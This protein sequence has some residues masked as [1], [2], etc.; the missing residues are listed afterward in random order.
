MLGSVIPAVASVTKATK[1]SKYFKSEPNGFSITFPEPNERQLNMM[2]ELEGKNITVGEYIERVYPELLKEIPED[3]KRRLYSS[4]IVWPSGNLNTKRTQ[5][6]ET[7]IQPQQVQWI[8]LIHKS[9]VE[10]PSWP[11]IKQSSWSYEIWPPISKINLLFMAVESYLWYRETP[12]SPIHFKSFAA[13][14]CSNCYEVNAEKTYTASVG[15]YWSVT[16]HHWGDSPPGYNPPE[17][18]AWTDSGWRYFGP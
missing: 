1:S 7:R 2:K 6:K 12:D 14:S 15:G 11:S 3:A 4:K 9:A 13:K 16:G 17:Y 8:V 18:D 10:N 5:S